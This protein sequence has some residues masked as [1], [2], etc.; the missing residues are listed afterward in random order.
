[1]IP[2]DTY[3]ATN[4]RNLSKWQLRILELVSIKVR[5]NIDFNLDNYF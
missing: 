3:P 2:K 5:R 4:F 1:M